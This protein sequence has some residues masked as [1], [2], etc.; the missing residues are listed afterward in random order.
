QILDHALNYVNSRVVLG[1]DNRLRGYPVGAFQGA[2][3]VV[4]NAELRT[5]SVDI[6]SAQVGAAA[7]YDVG[8]ANDD[9]HRF[10][11]KQGAGVGLRVL[12]PEFDRIV[13]RADWGFPLSPGYQALPGAFFVSFAQAFAMPSVSSPSV[14]SETL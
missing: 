11:L 4:A 8:D 5:T 1:G 6:L 12:F 14:L 10:Q 2:N 3:Q 7:F 13:F 9:I